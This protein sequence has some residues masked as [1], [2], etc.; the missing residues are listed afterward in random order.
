MSSKPL[1]TTYQIATENFKP[2]LDGT[3]NLELLGTSNLPRQTPEDQFLTFSEV[4][5]FRNSFYYIAELKCPHD[6][7]VTEI[8]IGHLTRNNGRILLV[9]ESKK[10]VIQEGTVLPNYGPFVSF[11]HKDHDQ[12]LTIMSYTPTSLTEIL[13]EPNS[14]PTSSDKSPPNAVKLKNN[15]ILAC[16]KNKMVP[17]TFEEL[18]GILKKYL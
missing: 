7:N 4:F 9:R 13:V 12:V 1:K 5:G 10:L 2:T 15:S 6:D 3:D 14:I 8:G 17:I 16:Y 11:K 18:A